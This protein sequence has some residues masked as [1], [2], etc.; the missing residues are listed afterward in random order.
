MCSLEFHELPLCTRLAFAV[1]HVL[2]AASRSRGSSLLGQSMTL[3]EET[4]TSLYMGDNLG[5]LGGEIDVASHPLPSGTTIE[6][7]KG[8]REAAE[9]KGGVRGGEASLSKAP[10]GGTQRVVPLLPP[11]ET[12]VRTHG[13]AVLPGHIKMQRSRAAPGRA[14]GSEQLSAQDAQR[15]LSEQLSAQD[16]AKPCRAESLWRQ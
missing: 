6:Q 7:P 3:K 13:R 10:E 5:C 11:H 9:G 14:R 16:E 2:L 1:G 15:S 8:S 4:L 12:L